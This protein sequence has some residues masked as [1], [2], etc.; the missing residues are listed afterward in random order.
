MKI[1]LVGKR[2]HLETIVGDVHRHA[3]NVQVEVVGPTPAPVNILERRAQSQFEPFEVAIMI[4]AGAAGDV[5]AHF[6]IKAIEQFRATVT[7]K[8]QEAVTGTLAG[9]P[10]IGEKPDDG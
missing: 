9:L 7:I 1:V 3:K 5:L 2:D 8:N 10:D 4:G 6:L